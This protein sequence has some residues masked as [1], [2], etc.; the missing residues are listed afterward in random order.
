MTHTLNKKESNAFIKKMLE[1]E[2]RPI[3]EKERK[4][5]QEINKSFPNP[6]LPIIEHRVVEER[7]YIMPLF[8]L[9]MTCSVLIGISYVLWGVLYQETQSNTIDF[10]IL[11]L[12]W[13]LYI[14]SIIKRGLWKPEKI[15]FV[16]HVILDEE[17]DGTTTKSK[18]FQLW[19]K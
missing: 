11:L 3:T 5:A 15:K 14:F 18:M 1:T 17:K 6:T 7:D 13:A 9:F 2:R 16:E 12:L 8:W 19:K 10:I 4:M